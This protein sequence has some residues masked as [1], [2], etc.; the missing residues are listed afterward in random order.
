MNLT[1]TMALDHAHEGIRIN[2]ICPGYMRTAMTTGFS[3]NPELEA[4]LRMRIPQGRGC[5]PVEVARTALF[6]ASDDASYMNG[7]ALVVD[8]G[9]S[10]HSGMPNFLKYSAPKPNLSNG[11]SNETS[12]RNG[13]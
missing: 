11:S 5:D 8:G 3:Q 6:L 9:T 4:D 7:H 13:D 10:A 1:R 12:G 2:G